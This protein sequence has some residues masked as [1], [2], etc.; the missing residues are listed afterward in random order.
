MTR[1]SAIN[2]ILIY[3]Q[4]LVCA[5][6]SPLKSSTNLF[7]RPLHWMIFFCHNRAAPAYDTRP[8]VRE[9]VIT[10]YWPGR[11]ILW[12]SS[13]PKGWWTLTHHILWALGFSVFDH[14]NSLSAGWG[15]LFFLALSL[16]LALPSCCYFTSFFFFTR[17]LMTTHFFYQPVVGES[18][19]PLCHSRTSGKNGTVPIE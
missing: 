4:I 1:V 3:I 8:F 18:A 17:N 11:R 6:D 10:H 13:D 16:K 14:L 2:R 19:V 9:K 15:L 12:T 5:V 7:V